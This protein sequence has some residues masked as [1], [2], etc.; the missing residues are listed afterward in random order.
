[1]KL[2]VTIHVIPVDNRF[3]WE[4]RDIEGRLIEDSLNWKQN[5]SRGK[6]LRTRNGKPFASTAMF[7]CA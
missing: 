1:M 2:S 4:L 5:P 3:A 6:P 7:G